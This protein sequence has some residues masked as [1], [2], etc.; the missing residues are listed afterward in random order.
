M[1][2]KVGAIKQVLNHYPTC[3]FSYGQ[4]ENINYKLLLMQCVV[5]VTAERSRPYL[6]THDS[7]DSTDY[8][9]AVYVDVSIH[10]MCLSA[11]DTCNIRTTHL[12]AVLAARD[13]M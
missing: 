11:L 9:N 2:S 1:C 13:T 4:T 10:Y 5:M 7:N 3:G 6:I 8:I 12:V